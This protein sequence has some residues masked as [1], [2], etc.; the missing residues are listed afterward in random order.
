MSDQLL[1][2]SNAMAGAVDKAGASVIRIE[3]RRR[4]PA[5]GIVW[6]E[7]GVIVT[8]HHVVQRED[9]I[10]IG[11][12]DGTKKKAKF[13]GRDPSTDLAVVKVDGVDLPVPSWRPLEQ[14]KVGHLVLALGRPSMNVNA[15]L[16]V[17]SSI[18]DRASRRGHGSLDAFVQ[19]DVVMYPGF[20]GGPLIDAEAGFVGLNTSALV[21]GVSLAVPFATIER[22]VAALLK[23][24]RIQRAYL[25]VGVQPVRLPDEFQSTLKRETGLMVVSIEADSPA[26][27]GGLLLGDVIVALDDTPMTHVDALLG[28]LAG[29]LIGEKVKLEIVRAGK[30]DAVEVEPVAKE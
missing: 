20:S 22:V 14:I 26:E 1:K 18:D 12:P 6:D 21:R 16:G 7:S 15:S 5:S 10:D 23:D 29:N 2:L 9:R 19:T 30:L 25:G 28:S 4:M 3:A 17:I 13:V 24:G 27:K 8:A 11:L